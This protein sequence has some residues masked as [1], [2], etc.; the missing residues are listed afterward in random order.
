M[1]PLA[2]VLPIIRRQ[3]THLRAPTRELSR[4]DSSARQRDFP[5][6]RLIWRCYSGW[7]SKKKALLRR[8]FKKRGLEPFGIGS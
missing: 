2:R 5:V 1:G 8:A 3:P 4:S 6:S 7:S